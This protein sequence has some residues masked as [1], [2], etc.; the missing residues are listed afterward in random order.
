MPHLIYSRNKK[1]KNVKDS[2][3]Q[4]IVLKKV[5][6]LQVEN[7][8]LFVTGQMRCAVSEQASKP[9]SEAQMG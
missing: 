5:L 1:K 6:C 8:F 4:R 7:C 2:K 9:E 3:G